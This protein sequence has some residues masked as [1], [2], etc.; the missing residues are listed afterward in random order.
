VR[1]HPA[2]GRKGLYLSEGI[3]RRVVG[4]SAES[5][6]QLLDV[7]WERIRTDASHYV[8]RWENGDLLLWD[9]RGLIHQAYPAAPGDDRMLFRIGVN[10][11]ELLP[12]SRGAVG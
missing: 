12:A 6:D 4:M 5:S 1:V 7:L 9:N 2:T 8:H 3:S 11:R 10:D